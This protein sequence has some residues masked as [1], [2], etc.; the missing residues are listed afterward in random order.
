MRKKHYDGKR[1]DVSDA[2]YGRHGEKLYHKIYGDDCTI[3]RTERGNEIDYRG[4]D[5]IVACPGK[6]DVKVGDR[7]RPHSTKKGMD[8]CDIN[9]ITI[10]DKE[11]HMIPKD[12][13][14]AVEDKEKN[15][16]CRWYQLDIQPLLAK[17]LEKKLKPSFR[18]INTDG[19]RFSAFD[20]DKLKY[21][22]LVK[23]S[24]NVKKLDK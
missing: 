20:V 24:Y 1:H 17:F 2:I 9:D 15:A 21:L 7:F 5:A 6:S 12:F 18:G 22:N 10:R 4:V 8:L 16:L 23:K 11:T 19:N 14:Y 13:I 3:I